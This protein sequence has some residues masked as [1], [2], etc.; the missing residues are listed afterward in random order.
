M[1]KKPIEKVLRIPRPL[2]LTLRA[3]DTNKAS[4]DPTQQKQQN[5]E[6]IDYLILQYVNQGYRLNNR[7][8]PLNELSIYL[9]I[10]EIYLIKRIT[11]HTEKIANLLGGSDGLNT[12]RVA[13]KLALN[14]GLNAAVEAE[15][16]LH[17]LKASQG[18]Q[19]TAFT[20]TE[21]NKA[22]TNMVNAAKM[23]NDVADSLLGSKGPTGSG[24]N[25]L[26]NRPDEVQIGHRYLTAETAA[27]MLDEQAQPTALKAP[28]IITQSI[29]IEALK[30]LPEVRA[31]HQD[32]R[33]IGIKYDGTQAEINEQDEARKMA[34]P[35]D[36]HTDRRQGNENVVDMDDLDEDAEIG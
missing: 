18:G 12:A 16:Q 2:G 15:V 31:N 30:G 3:R 11:K 26:I 20:S 5:E 33:G 22:V 19:Y 35:T 10:P 32:L 6:L 24:T 1:K 36:H 9:N 34:H 17:T 4:A 14:F 23:L 28:E 25:I 8:V 7:T 27:K 21:V 29:P 13:K